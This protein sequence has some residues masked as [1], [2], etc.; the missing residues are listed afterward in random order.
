MARTRMPPVK[1]VVIG[2]VALRVVNCLVLGTYFDPDEH[3][4]SAEVAH[5]ALFGYGQLTW[6]WEPEVALRGFLHPALSSLL[7]LWLASL[8]PLPSS[9]SSAPLLSAAPRM[10]HS[11]V[12]AAVDL[13]CY[14]LCRRL[15]PGPPS[16]LP[17][18]ALLLSLSDWFLFYALPRPLSNTLETLF[19]LAAL[20]FL[21]LTFKYSSSSPTSLSSSS[22]STFA[23][24]FFATVAVLIRPTAAIFWLPVAIF[25]LTNTCSSAPSAA[26]AIRLLLKLCKEAIYAAALPLLVSCLLDRWFYGQWVLVPLNFFRFNVLNGL[27]SFY[28]SHPW[29]WYLSNALP[30]VL[31]SFL[32]LPFL[33]IYLVVPS[34]TSVSASFPSSLSSVSSFTSFTASFTPPPSPPFPSSSAAASSCS[35]SSLLAAFHSPSPISPPA[36]RF[37]RLCVFIIGFTI[38]VLSLLE[39]KELRFLLPIVPLLLIL[40]AL[41]LERLL[42]AAASFRRGLFRSL[43]TIVLAALFVAQ[44]PAM[45]Y[46]GVFHQRG[47]I[48]VMAHIRDHPEVSSVHFLMPCHSTPFYASVHRNLSLVALQCRPPLPGEAHYDEADDFYSRPLSFLTQR[49]QDPDALP[50]HFVLFEP[51]LHEIRPFFD[52]WGYVIDKRF[53]HTAT[54][55]DRRHGDVL[56][57]SRES[58]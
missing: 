31:L 27:S 20:Y 48:D 3:W 40:A 15:F 16:A 7:P 14:A 52:D 56:L 28:G 54:P 38:A 30:T 58:R 35:L 21:P 51:L 32:P 18:L 2:V 29:H 19:S 11:L 4:Q 50:S 42:V 9:F 55:V 34:S 33:G 23:C 36:A 1:W 37:L 26:I 17:L 8:L 6:E 57:F 53:W 24:F 47:V 43:A 10:A 45:A 44:L 46:L 13:L 41:G 12:A 5:K 22:S 49:Y 25:L 39:H